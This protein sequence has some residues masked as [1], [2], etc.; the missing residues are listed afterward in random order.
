M[1]WI[2]FWILAAV[3]YWW[4]NFFTKYAWERLNPTLALV[5]LTLTTLTFSLILFF[6][7]KD[8]ISLKV[9]KDW[10]WPILAWILAWIAEI[11]YLKM[12]A[13]WAPLAL[14]N[15]MVVWWTI[16]VAT[17]LWILIIKEDINIIKWL[18]IIMILFWILLIIKN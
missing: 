18:W 17:I 16:V 6:L 8:T 14:G 1:N 3:S 13:N 4:Y 11:F 5:L 2:L 10:I 15:P 12:Y 7:S 9:S